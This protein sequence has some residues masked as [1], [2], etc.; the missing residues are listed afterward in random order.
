MAA[1]VKK[2][3]TTALPKSVSKKL[4]YMEQREFEQIEGKIMEAEGE[5]E[6]CQVQMND[7]KVMADRD[8]IHDVCER[9]GVAEENVRKLY[10]RWEELEAKR[11]G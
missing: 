11:G 1:P 5:V 4:S 3:A 2:A 10:A 8:K 7:P 9:L 6:A